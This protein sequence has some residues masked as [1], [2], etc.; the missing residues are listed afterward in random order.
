VNAARGVALMVVPQKI[1]SEGFQWEVIALDGMKRT[2]AAEKWSIR[3][4]QA[5]CSRSVLAGERRLKPKPG[6]RSST[7]RMSMSAGVV[8]NDAGT[9][10]AVDS[11]KTTR[12]AISSVVNE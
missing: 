6:E 2:N 7:R 9:R 3:L 4:L 12:G 10:P 11:L 1:R 8:A 5:D